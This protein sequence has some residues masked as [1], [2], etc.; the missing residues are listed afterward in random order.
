LGTI[1]GY[2]KIPPYWKQGL[3]EAEGIDFKYT[4][5]SLSKV[6]AIGLKHA[7]QTVQRNGGIV[8][9]EQVTIKLQTPTPVK[10]EQS[11]AGHFPVSRLK[12]NKRLKD[13]Y[14]FEFN[15]IGFV[16]AG[17]TAK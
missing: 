10:L 5:T 6:Y 16:V 12:I 8:Q 9:G 14:S 15:G 4:T 17:T 3:A 1:L 2:D 11:F 13:E 7:L